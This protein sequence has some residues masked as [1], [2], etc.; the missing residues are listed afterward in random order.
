MA[1]R[2]YGSRTSER[3]SDF[4]D[5]EELYWRLDKV[6]NDV[7][8][9]PKTGKGRANVGNIGNVEFQESGNDP[10]VIV[11]LPALRFKTRGDDAMRVINAIA[12]LMGTV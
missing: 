6:W 4:P 2:R 1:A 7:D 10:A 9:D 5:A 8:F 3:S 12:K 11:K